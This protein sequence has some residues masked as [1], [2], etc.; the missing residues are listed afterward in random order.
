[1]PGMYVISFSAVATYS[2]EEVQ[3]SAELGENW[4]E[5]EAK[6]NCRFFFVIKTKMFTSRKF[7]PKQ[8]WSTTANVEEVLHWRTQPD[9]FFLRV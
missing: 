6:R 7:H 3:P 4:L 2:S 9:R 8:T 1:M 5:I